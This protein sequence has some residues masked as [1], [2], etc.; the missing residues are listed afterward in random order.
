MPKLLIEAIV[1]EISD[2]L[3]TITIDFGDDKV[4][5]VMLRSAFRKHI[6]HGRIDL[7]AADRRQ[8]EQLINLHGKCTCMPGRQC[9]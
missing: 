3:V 4:S 7:D 9:G 6:E 2:E 5:G 8:R 1:T